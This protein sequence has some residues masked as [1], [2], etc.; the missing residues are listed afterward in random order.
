MIIDGLSIRLAVE[1]DIEH[2]KRWVADPKVFCWFPFTSEEEIDKT[3]QYVSG[4]MNRQAVIAAE[5]DGQPCGI[6]G[7]ELPD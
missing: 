3:A 7:F 4:F 6:A 2:W 5:H 1:S